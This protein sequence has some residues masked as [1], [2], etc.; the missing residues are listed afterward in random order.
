MGFTEESK[1]AMIEG[2][3]QA[4]A[5]DA[6][7]VALGERRRGGSRKTPE[8]T[9]KR[10]ETVE[11]AITQSS[12]LK[13]LALIQE[14]LDLSSALANGDG[15]VD[16]A[17]LESRFVAVAATYSERKG[18]SAK[19]WRAVGVPA[20]VLQEAGLVAPRARRAPRE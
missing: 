7:L 12:G 3:A 10:L 15:H 5:I 19:A 8:G 1:R 20:R 11:A 14:R 4:R 13:R 9:A 17:E 16:L 6:Y 2:R 18:I